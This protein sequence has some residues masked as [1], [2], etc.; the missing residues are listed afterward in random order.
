MHLY[1]SMQMWPAS[2]RRFLT[3]CIQLVSLSTFCP[4]ACTPL[5]SF[6]FLIIPVPSPLSRSFP[7]SFPCLQ[8]HRDAQPRVCLNIDCCH[9]LSHPLENISIDCLRLTH[10]TTHHDHMIHPSPLLDSPTGTQTHY[11]H[12]YLGI[13]TARPTL[14][15]HAP[16][17]RRVDGCGIRLDALFHPLP[18]STSDS[19]AHEVHVV[20]PVSSVVQP[21][22]LHSTALLAWPPHRC[23]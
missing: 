3:I 10:V 22:H 19:A 2:L 7:E 9:S 14:Q 12:G 1:K 16:S 21:N 8:R 20:L 6:V 13:E 17:P 18:D 5:F 4:P 23:I 15:R 11:R